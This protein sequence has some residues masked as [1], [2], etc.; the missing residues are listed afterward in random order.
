MTSI[1]AC[2]NFFSNP[3][4]RLRCF[5]F[6]A[7]CTSWLS[8]TVA[9]HVLRVGRHDARSQNAAAFADRPSQGHDACLMFAL[10]PSKTLFLTSWVPFL[11]TFPHHVSKLVAIEAHTHYRVATV[12]F[13]MSL[14][15]LLTVPACLDHLWPCLR[16][17]CVCAAKK[18]GQVGQAPHVS[19][20]A[21]TPK[22]F[23]SDCCVHH[24]RTHGT[25]LTSQQQQCS[26]LDV[27]LLRLVESQREHQTCHSPRVAKT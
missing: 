7:S 12:S 26:W 1:E 4:L 5:R 18:N 24:K 11:K 10:L 27:E 2:I 15:R 6:L 3:T 9:Y 19:A 25:L 14:L 20:A 22:R 17:I 16:H 23:I 8:L 21:G 13:T